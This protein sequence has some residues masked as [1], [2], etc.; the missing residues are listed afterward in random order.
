MRFFIYSPVISSFQYHSTW[1][2][3]LFTMYLLHLNSENAVKRSTD[4]STPHSMSKQNAT[5]HVFVAHLREGIRRCTDRCNNISFS[6]S[7]MINTSKGALKASKPIPLV[8]MDAR[9]FR[10][11]QASVDFLY[12]VEIAR[13]HWGQRA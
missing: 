1:K 12:S 8:S 4:K 7:A 10:S 3:I 13:T 6:K 5:H 2:M 11:R 9:S